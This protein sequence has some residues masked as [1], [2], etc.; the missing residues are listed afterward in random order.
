MTNKKLIK[1][2]NM[3]KGLK[4]LLIVFVHSILSAVI[5]LLMP[6]SQ[7]YKD[8]MNADSN[9]L[10]IIFLVICSAFICFAIC[11]VAANSNWGHKTHCRDYFRFLYD[12]L[13]FVSAGNV[14]FRKC[15]Y[16]PLED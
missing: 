13:I 1:G 6:H 16:S 12:W 15:F 8:M 7:E 10:T 3:K 5:P 4:F 9:P 2:V 14:S 11:Y